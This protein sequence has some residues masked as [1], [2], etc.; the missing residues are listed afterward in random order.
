MAV[1]VAP[2]VVVVVIPGFG[3]HRLDARQAHV[4]GAIH[5]RAGA[6]Q[7]AG[8]REG[9]VVVMHE[10]HLADAMRH[11]D[12]VAHRVVQ[13]RGH[14]RAEHRFARVGERLA[15]RERQLAIAAVAVVNEVVAV[16]AQHAVAPMRVA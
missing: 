12:L 15:D 5:R 4:N 8:D 14:F 11:H 7:D 13:R 10:T 16:G 2:V 1:P 3:M 6:R 9:R